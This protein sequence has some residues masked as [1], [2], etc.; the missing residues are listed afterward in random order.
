[1]KPTELLF[2]TCRDIT[3]A[4]SFGTFWAEENRN[5]ELRWN[6]SASCR[7]IQPATCEAHL[8]QLRGTRRK[9][10]CEYCQL[11]PQYRKCRRRMP[12]RCFAKYS[13]LCTTN[14]CL[15]RA[16]LRCEEVAYQKLKSKSA[17]E[18]THE[19]REFETLS[20]DIHFQ[21]FL[22]RN[23]E[24]VREA[25]SDSLQQHGYISLFSIIIMIVL[26]LYI[27]SVYRKTLLVTSL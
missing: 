8:F 14:F 9:H 2:E 24:T 11:L 7:A 21:T 13:F 12:G 10:P 23:A 17:L 27:E 4:Q 15:C 6:Y 3:P 20:G 18:D 19:E 26:S 25:V 1:M 16:E 5:T 22:H